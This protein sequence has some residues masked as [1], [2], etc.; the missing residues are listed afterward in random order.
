MA[1]ADSHLRLR[2]GRT[3]HQ[4]GRKLSA[5]PC[6][7]SQ[8]LAPRRQLGCRS[9]RRR[10][11]QRHRILKT[12]WDQSQGVPSRRPPSPSQRHHF[13]GA[14][15]DTRR[16][17]A[18]PFR[19]TSCL[20]PLRPPLNRGLAD[21]D[22]LPPSD[23][24]P[25]PPTLAPT[26]TAETLT[27]QLSYDLALRASADCH[28]PKRGGA[29]PGGLR[30]TP[31]WHRGLPAPR[32]ARRLSNSRATGAEHHRVLHRTLTQG[33]SARVP[34]L[35]LQTSGGNV[36]DPQRAPPTSSTNQF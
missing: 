10:Y 1:K 6:A 17:A 23:L 31:G 21:R 11:R 25:A 8:K 2:R 14:L 33:Q 18:P 19:P 5:S 16:L 29:H 15:A 22:R 28:Q 20:A 9:P 34:P 32:P 4:L 3:R 35:A 12:P 7:R 13:R 30:K 36:A 27:L 26:W 24:R